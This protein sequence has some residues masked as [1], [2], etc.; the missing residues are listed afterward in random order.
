MSDLKVRLRTRLA[1]GNEWPK[2]AALLINHY[3]KEVAEDDMRMLSFAV[4]DLPP[5]INHQYAAGRAG[6]KRGFRLTPEAQAFRWMTKK[7]I[8]SKQFNWHP[9]G[10]VAALLFFENPH[11]ITQEFRVRAADADNLVKPTLDAVKI[12]ARMPDELI[13]QAHVFKISSKRKRTIVYLF[14]LGD[15]VEFFG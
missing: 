1:L 15:V 4:N 9:K 2:A 8:G 6:N 5:S 7:A 14:D 12:S 3:V 11:W 13:W 10:I